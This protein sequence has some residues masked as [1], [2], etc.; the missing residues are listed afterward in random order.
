MDHLLF[1][2]ETPEQRTRRS[3][4][5]LAYMDTFSGNGWTRYDEACRNVMDRIAAVIAK[6]VERGE[7]SIEK[8]GYIVARFRVVDED[9]AISTLKK[10][11]LKQA[12]S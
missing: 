5:W 12:A 6:K 1:A 11:Y 7:M 9:A 10:Y 4:E 3:D 2:G 8:A